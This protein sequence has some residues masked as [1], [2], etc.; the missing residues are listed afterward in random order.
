[1]ENDF[2]PDGDSVTFQGIATQ[3]QNGWLQGV[4]GGVWKYF[5]NSGF[6]GFDS[7]SY[8]IR[9]SLG[10]TKTA[11]VY[12]LVEPQETPNAPYGC[13][14]PAD[15]SY[16]GR[17]NPSGGALS[18][19]ASTGENASGPQYKDP[20]N[21]ATGRENYTPDPD[22]SIYNPNGPS[23]LFQR[24][25]VGAQVVA[26]PRG[27]GSPGLSRG[28]VH[29]YD[30]S[31]QGTS[32]SWGALKLMYPNGATENLTP[33]LSGGS[34][35]GAFNTVAGAPYIVSGVAGSPAGTWQSVT[36]TWNDQTQWKFTLLSGT[37]YALNHLTNRTGQ[38]LNFS[39]NTSRALTQVSDAAT[40]TALLTLA[41]SS[42]GKLS[43]A[44]DTY[45]R[46]V[47]YTFSP[48]NE[49]VQ[50]AL[51]TV[52]QVV[53]A[54]TSNPAAH[55][56]YTYDI[57]KGQ[58]LNTITVPSPTG[59]G[60]STATINYN[61]VGKVS[62]LVDANGNQH[63]YTYNSSTTQVQ[64]KDSANN[65]A[66]AWTQKFNSSGL[67]TGITDAA[68]HSST[69]SYTDSANPLKP[70]SVADRNNHTT[71]YTYDSFGNVLTGTSPRNVTTTYT[72]S[73]TNFALGRL[74]SIQEGTKPQTSFSYYEPSGL[75]QTITR[76]EPN[77]GAG[78]TSTSFTYD[79]LG[80]LLTVTTPGNDSVVSITTTLNY[81]TDGGYSQSAKVGQP[82]TVTDNLGH[83]THLRYDSQGRTISVT[84]AIGNETGFSYNLVGQPL[85]TTYPTT[86][87][88]G[89]GNSH[90]TN[91]YFYV[92][93]PLATVT[94]YDESNMQV[95]QVTHAYGPEGESLSISGSTE[96]AT[97]TYDALYRLKTLKDGNN[98]ATTYS[99]NNLGFVASITMPGGEATQFT[100]YDNAGNLLQRIDGNNVTTNYVYNDLESFLT[101]IQYPAT[102]SLNIHFTYDGYG[103]RSGM[104]DGTGS[105]SYSYGNL[106]EL[107]STTTTYTGL[108]AK[109]ISYSYFAN[110]SRATMTTPA[111][112]L[113][114]SYDAAG[115]PS[116]M[117]NPFSETTSWS[118]QNNN[119]L[120]TQTLANGATAT[121]AYNAMGQVTRLLNQIGSAT[122]S[123]FSGIAYDGVGNRTSVTASIPG[124]TSL[125]GTTGYT[126]DSQN[127]L[128]QEASTRNGG[129][130]DSF[131]YD[132]AANPIS[133]KGVT[134]T[135]NSN[136][137]QTGTGFAY[138][139]NGNPTTYS[140]TQ[141]T[142]DPENRMTAFSNV[143]TAAYNGEGLRTWKQ[144]AISRIYFLYDGVIPVVEFDATGAIISTNT[145]GA[146]GL[147][148]RRDGSS[149]VFYTFDSE[150]NVC[151][152][153]DASG[154]V[155][156]SH[157]F[158]AFG[159]SLT[160]SS[161][162]PFGYK[163]QVGYYTDNETGLQNLTYRYYNQSTGRFLTP[164]PIGQNGGINVY[165]YVRNN[166][167]SYADPLG[168]AP[169]ISEHWRSVGGDLA[170]AL[171]AFIQD[172]C[173]EKGDGPYV[174]K[175]DLPPGFDSSDGP[176]TSSPFGDGACMQL[177]QI[178]LERQG[179]PLGPAGF[180]RLKQGPAVMGIGGIRPGTVIASGWRDG[181]YP[182][183]YPHG[184]HAAIYLRSVPNGFVVLEQVNG[185]LQVDT[186]IAGVGGYYSNANAY[187]VVLTGQPV[188]GVPARQ[189]YP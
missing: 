43:T 143:L 61:S 135:Y 104:I 90:S 7:F 52:S 67:D 11:M 85:T 173:T 69:T 172:F 91:A 21:L 155:L 6:S 83:T 126:Y 112:T 166:P 118:Y 120:Q 27:Y 188:A 24:S 156:A 110:G 64:V 68:T 130:T 62:S 106:S 142:F 36:I 97:K 164:D 47:A 65:V 141:L 73:Y 58:Q 66:L 5:P 170:A 29:N 125:D 20:V 10:L 75:I 63:A 168:L 162:D 80:N 153:S 12:V 16:Q 186:K 158:S 160:T 32:G 57:T 183:Y 184:N 93:G 101:D 60:N 25:Y 9:D 48:G 181:Y 74:M 174:I 59:S 44:T 116:S 79:T 187:N 15:T 70:T 84:D 95:R 182:N 167:L 41:Y 185:H 88:T 49:T 40:S 134:K 23:V 51:T 152:R 115:R 144:N 18:M 121:Y 137:Q 42:N 108:S 26:E 82:L 163:A 150:A 176:V 8:T 131:S 100:S 146:A 50:S 13:S 149:S 171:F 113:N 56:T 105:N 31:L 180:G 81:T 133:F 98:N 128:T 161:S 45:G 114:Y 103:R 123:D 53:T 165:S 177:V 119:W 139:G 2:D 92:G 33:Q 140:G 136:N 159:T 39:W 127:Q 169:E 34:P 3:P 22:L 30:V 28:W 111:G 14:C 96:P 77:N 37:T 117:T 107:L 19:L 148:S 179:T 129:F 124:A 89:S 76:P 151:D 175:L 102:T 138:D 147:I 78:T 55:W 54:G 35:T 109:T 145:F 154:I 99:Y 87:Q 157:L 94:V 38:S 17:F 46:Q 189:R 86:G 178:M 1:M 122:I 4:S 71:L 132:S 72:W